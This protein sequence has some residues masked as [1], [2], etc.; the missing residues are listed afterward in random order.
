MTLDSYHNYVITTNHDKAVKVEQGERRFFIVHS[1]FPPA[2][3]DWHALVDA[4][5]DPDTIEAYIQYLLSI[6]TKGFIKGR[7]PI[8]EA[9]KAAMAKQRPVG[10]A[11]LQALCED[12][13]MLCTGDYDGSCDKY[14]IKSRADRP[15]SEREAF[16]SCLGDEARFKKDLIS[17]RGQANSAIGTVWSGKWQA[18]FNMHAHYLTLSAAK[19]VFAS[20]LLRIESMFVNSVCICSSSFTMSRIPG[21]SLQ[22]RCR[23]AGGSGYVSNP[24]MGKLTENQRPRLEQR[25][26]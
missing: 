11:F 23:C 14:M 19:N 10:A 9:K 5:S 12:P 1:A 25:N 16:A 24:E 17:V 21:H 4:V 26:I 22:F 18:P 6:D 7:A 20:S 2:D 15:E 13:R 8:T 3:Y